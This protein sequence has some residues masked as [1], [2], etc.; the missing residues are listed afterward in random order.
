MAD[1]DKVDIYSGFKKTLL[2]ELIETRLDEMSGDQ[3]ER[4]YDIVNADQEAAF[5]VPKAEQ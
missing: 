5:I 4:L 1:N 3:V 2:C